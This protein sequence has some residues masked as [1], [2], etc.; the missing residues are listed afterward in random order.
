[1]NLN[2]S[3]NNGQEGTGVSG[4]AG[5]SPA[6]VLIQNP[7][8]ETLALHPSNDPGHYTLTD[9]LSTSPAVRLELGRGPDGVHSLYKIFVE[10]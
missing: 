1:M 5:V 7:S 10:F 6:S 9:K 2:R 8:G 4:S 3:T